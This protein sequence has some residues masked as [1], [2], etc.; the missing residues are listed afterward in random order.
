MNPL[1]N[2]AVRSL[3]SP[4]TVEGIMATVV[5]KTMTHKSRGPS[6]TVQRIVTTE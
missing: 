5:G 1:S 6:V 2:E 4:V 3:V